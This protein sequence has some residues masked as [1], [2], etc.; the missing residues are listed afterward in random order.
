MRQS[1]IRVPDDLAERLKD[2]VATEQPSVNA[3]VVDAVE[4]A[5]SHPASRRQA[6]RARNAHALVERIP[7]GSPDRVRRGEPAPEGGPVLSAALEAD[8]SGR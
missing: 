3:T 8:R 5:L 4:Q 6:W 7:R 2:R 1:I